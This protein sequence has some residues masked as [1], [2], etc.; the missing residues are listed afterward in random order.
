MTHGDP[1]RPDEDRDRRIV[2]WWRFTRPHHTSQRWNP[3]RLCG[4][5]TTALG[6]RLTETA[7]P[8]AERGVGH[9][10]TRRELPRRLA[11]R[12]PRPEP[13]P[14][15]PPAS[16][17]PAR[18]ALPRSGGRTRFTQ[19]IQSHPHRRTTREALGR[20]HDDP[21]LGP[22]RRSRSRAWLPPPQG[23]QRHEGVRREAQAARQRARSSSA[24]R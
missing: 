11:A 24:H 7:R 8:V 15:T 18:C 9:T 19:G 14:P 4:P 6:P 5:R 1:D 10:S 17:S 12:P 3:H 23:P 16:S 22:R 21:S 13:T 2:C 20:R